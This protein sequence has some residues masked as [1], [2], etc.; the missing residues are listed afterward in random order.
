MSSVN[1][2]NI[3]N[4]ITKYLTYGCQNVNDLE[5]NKCCYFYTICKKCNKFTC[6][7]CHGLFRINAYE[8]E[9]GSCSE[10]KKYYKVPE[11]WKYDRN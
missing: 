1:N 8:F 6:E 4:I 9:C 5:K 11:S 7:S 3:N 10:L 2:K